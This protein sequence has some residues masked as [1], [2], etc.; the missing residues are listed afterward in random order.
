[1]HKPKIGRADWHALYI[2]YNNCILF[3]LSEALDGANHL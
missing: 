2:T 3:E 1:M